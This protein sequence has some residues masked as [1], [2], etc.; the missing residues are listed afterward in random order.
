M[1]VDVRFQ[2]RKLA[3]QRLCLQVAQ[4]WMECGLICGMGTRSAE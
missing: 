2:D 3:L 1:L 4:S